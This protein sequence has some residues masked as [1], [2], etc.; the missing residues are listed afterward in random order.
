M[1]LALELASC[2]GCEFFWD[3]IC[4]Q[5]FALLLTV[6][7]KTSHSFDFPNKHLLFLY[8]FLRFWLARTCGSYLHRPLWSIGA[9]SHV[10][11]L[12]TYTVCKSTSRDSCHA[13][14][15]M[16]HCRGDWKNLWWID[17]GVWSGQESAVSPARNTNIFLCHGLGAT[18]W[19]IDDWRKWAAD[20][21]CKR[22]GWFMKT[23]EQEVLDRSCF[24]LQSFF[25]SLGSHVAQFEARDF[26]SPMSVPLSLCQCS[27]CCST[28]CGLNAL[29]TTPRCWP[30]A[31]WRLQHH[32]RFSR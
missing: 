19:C 17:F 32:L 22:I 30:M 16:F 15:P 9:P 26:L 24:D 5:A 4:P 12:C 18:L 2:L 14:S 23:I 1:S 3:A 29:T 10:R 11:L 31:S 21:P 20:N 27:F 7:N 25:C 8:F 28:T 13:S 6:S